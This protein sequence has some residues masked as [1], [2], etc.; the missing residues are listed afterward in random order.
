MTYDI[1]IYYVKKIQTKNGMQQD[2]FVKRKVL[3]EDHLR[4]I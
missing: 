3:S 2:Y 1:M 4:P